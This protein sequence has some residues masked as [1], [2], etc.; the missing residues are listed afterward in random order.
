MPKKKKYDK[1]L[2]LDM[3]FDEAL[4]RFAAVDPKEIVAGPTDD[5]VSLRED[6]TGHRFIIYSTPNG[7]RAE[8]RYDGGTF[9]ATQSQ[10]VEMFG[11]DLSGIS[12]H[13]NNIFDEGEL[14][15]EGTIAKIA[16]VALEGK[17]QVTRSVDAYNLNAIIS[18]GYRVGSVQGTMFRIW[19]T[20]KLFQ[21]LTKGFYI[22][23]AR[24]KNPEQPSVIDELRETIREIR[25]STQNVYREVKR[26]CSM[27]QD[28]NGSDQS[29][30]DFF[31]AM[32]N[33]LLYVAVTKTA[34]EIIMERADVAKPDMGLTHHTGKRGVPTQDD[35]VV[36]NNYL[37]EPEAKVKNRATT[38]L[39][40]YFEE[41]I[42]QGRLVTMA[43]AERKL[44][45][46]INFN[47]WPLLRNRGYVKGDSA[48]EHAKNLLKHYKQRTLN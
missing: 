26:I 27:C 24:L 23:K 2:T 40:D 15:R 46:F 48:R 45:E 11:V 31:A 29:A 22:D 8:L 16:R 39:L 4:G 17:R 12:R 10:M 36:A 47:Q 30:R 6:D 20:D 3:D 14:P 19:S 35:V 7:P 5:R 18:V 44:N 43:E 32:E 9:W 34:G 28:Y 13:L 1:P 25:A 41:Q 37:F 21:I 33:K 38:M 42:D